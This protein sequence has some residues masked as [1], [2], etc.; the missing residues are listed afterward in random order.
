MWRDRRFAGSEQLWVSPPKDAFVRVPDQV[1]KTAV[2][3][4][5]DG[6]SG[7]EYGGTGYIVAVDYSPEYL[8]TAPMEPTISAFRY[9]FRFL[10]TA[11]HVAEKLEGVDFY[12]RANGLDGS[13]LELKQDC[14]NAKWWYHPTDRDSVD[15]AAML[16]PT[17]TAMCLDIESIAVSMFAG[18]RMIKEANLGVGDEVFIAG[19]FKK[20]KGASRNIPIIRTGNVAMMPKEKIPFPTKERPDQWLYA[21]LLE[22]RSIGGLSGSPVFIRETLRL[23]VQADQNGR[24][25]SQDERLTALTSGDIIT[26]NKVPEVKISWEGEM[27]GLG[28]FHFFG[29][30]IGHWQ[31]DVG[32]NDTQAEAVN[33]GIAP[34]VPAEKILEVFTQTEVLEAMASMSDELKEKKQKRDGVGVMDSGFAPTQKTEQGY[35]LPVPTKEEFFDALTKA[36]RRVKPD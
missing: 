24:L 13:L 31:V 20:A 7:R 33:F 23:S 4:G 11:A 27:Q 30:L 15:A 25:S 3:L 17:E 2:F 19:L 18:Q 10:V 6:P 21:D 22:S 32:F 28:R 1:L 5:I 8:F 14:E 9:P 12:I 34:M 29:S 26:I 36:T 35:K 16:L